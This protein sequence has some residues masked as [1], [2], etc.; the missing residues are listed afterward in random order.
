MARPVTRATA[1][2]ALRAL[3]SGKVI[4]LGRA[5]I[6]VVDPERLLLAAR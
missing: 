4:S 5:R 3:A 6:T 2:R 1:N